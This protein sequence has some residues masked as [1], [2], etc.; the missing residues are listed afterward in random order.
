MGASTG[1]LGAVNA[2]PV[3]IKRHISIF[4]AFTQV[5]SL[6]LNLNTLFITQNLTKSIS[7]L[8]QVIELSLFSTTSCDLK[9]K[10]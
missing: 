3:D 2:Q 1:A 10:I 5:L 4:K 9:L 7:T 8:T 6:I